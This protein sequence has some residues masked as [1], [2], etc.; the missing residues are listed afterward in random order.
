MIGYYGVV[1]VRGTP[2]SGKTTLANLLA[3]R[4][5]NT[6]RVVF[7]ENWGISPLSST[8]YLVSRA[9]RAG[10]LDVTKDDFFGRRHDNLIFIIDEAQVTYVDTLLWYTAIKTRIGLF[11]GPSFCL[12][13]S[14]GSPNTGAP[15]FNYPVA[16]TPPILRKEQRVSLTIPA[17]SQM[18]K[19]SLFYT[20]SEF[21]DVIARFCQ[22]PSVDFT[23]AEDL[24]NHLYS[25][26]DGHPGIVHALLT[27]IQSVRTH[28]RGNTIYSNNSICRFTETDSKELR[29]EDSPLTISVETWM[30]TRN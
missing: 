25:F 23:L 26:T 21:K 29:Y 3:Q 1:H 20:T 30:T 15:S 11:S 10:Y 6:H 19:I 12:F 27:F 22:Q 18:P 2:A 8:D 14:Y 16:T 5:K 24:Q 7:I 17:G 9:H 28:I 4:L 13:S